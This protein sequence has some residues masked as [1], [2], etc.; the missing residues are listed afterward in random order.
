MRKPKASKPKPK[1]KIDDG[2]PAF[3]YYGMTL[4]QWYAGQAIAGM[5][6]NPGYEHSSHEAM[7]W[8]AYDLADELIRQSNDPIT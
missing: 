8:Q 3:F 1:P 2:G 7:V 4:R 5:M 6:A